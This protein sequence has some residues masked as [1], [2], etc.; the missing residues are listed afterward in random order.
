[1]NNYKPYVKPLTD[2]KDFQY[3]VLKPVDV[4][5][6]TLR[7]NT[8]LLELAKAKGF[9]NGDTPYNQ[10]FSSMFYKGGS[11]MFQKGLDEK[12]K[13]QAWW[14]FKA[15]ASSFEPKHEE[16]EAICALILSELAEV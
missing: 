9:Y 6:S 1:M 11:I 8:Q 13:E 15:L 12:R 2:I 3:P 7:T 10:L 16:K 5:F 14:Y 4:A